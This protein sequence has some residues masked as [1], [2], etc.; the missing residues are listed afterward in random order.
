M[1]SYVVPRVGSVEVTVHRHDFGL[2]NDSV[3][4]LTAVRRPDGR[5]VDTV[6]H[7]RVAQYL[8][9]IGVL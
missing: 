7:E 2:C 5:A 6:A 4:L 9:S 3:T 1:G 8:E